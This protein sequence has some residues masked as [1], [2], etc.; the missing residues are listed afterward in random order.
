V[1]EAAL[2]SGVPYTYYPF[3]GDI[4]LM[5]FWDHEPDKLRRLHA[6]LIRESILGARTVMSHLAPFRQ[7]LEKIRRNG[8][9]Y[10]NFIV[11]TER[12]APTHKSIPS[13][14]PPTLGSI[15]EGSTI[16]FM[17]SRQDFYWKGS[18]KFLKCYARCVRSGA[19]LFLIA[20]GWGK[21]LIQSKQIVQSAGVSQSVYWLPF[22]LSKPYLIQMYNYCDVVADQFSLGIYGTSLLE[23]LACGKTVMSYIDHDAQAATLKQWSP[24]PILNAFSEQQIELWL[25]Q[26]SCGGVD[27]N[28]H[29][30]EAR[31]WIIEHHTDSGVRTIADIVSAG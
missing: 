27:L 12:Y 3:G 17:P 4:N 13:C 14:L 18:D 20:A 31:Q 5:P 26:L 21:D 16:I 11:D 6:H 8:F 9:V 25:T 2:A 15:T 30:K 10:F 28:R 7:S 24:P 23:A 22:A 19:K 1:V 29:G